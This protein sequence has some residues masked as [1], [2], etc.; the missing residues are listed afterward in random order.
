MRRA[1]VTR[2]WGWP[3]ARARARAC[4]CACVPETSVRCGQ[5]VGRPRIG[6]APDR[7]RA[8]VVRLGTAAR[9]PRGRAHQVALTVMES[10]TNSTPTMS[11]RSASDTASVRPAVRELGP[12]LLSRLKPVK[13]EVPWHVKRAAKILPGVSQAPGF[14]AAPQHP[15]PPPL[16]N[17]RHVEDID[18]Q[19][20]EIAQQVQGPRPAHRHRGR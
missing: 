7:E 4:S 8:R 16:L 13:H 2:P 9:C 5:R 3:R 12:G 14:H 6:F 1:A 15:P 19:S 18:K 20:A 17:A 11:A 10:V